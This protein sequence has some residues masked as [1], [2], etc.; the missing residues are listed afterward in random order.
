MIEPGQ[1][2]TDSPLRQVPADYC[3]P[4]AARWHTLAEGPEAGRTLFYYDCVVGDG[5]PEA[6]VLFVHGNPECSYT[7]RHIRDALIA[8]DRPLRLIA[9]DH[10]GFGLSDQARFEMVDFHHARHLAELVRHLDLDDVTLVIHDW[11][12]PIGIGAFL[13]EPARVR[14]L[15]LM[16]TTVF[17]MP[18]EGYTYANWPIPWLPWCRTPSVVPDKLW[19]GVAAYVVSHAEPQSRAA[20][21]W[22]VLRYLGKHARHGFAPGTPEAVWSDQMR[23]VA[24]ARASKRHVRQTPVWGH[25]YRY[26]DPRH[27]PQDNRDFYRRLH[28]MVPEAWGPEGQHIGVAGYFGAWDPCGKPEVIRQ[29]QEA[30]PQMRDRTH[31]YPD[32]GH[33]IEEYKGPE[34]A[35]SILALN[36]LA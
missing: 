16:N 3:P 15:L 22:G 28:R 34:M 6:T 12:G 7:Y 21:L 35:R 20:F 29:W 9:V 11:G 30:L 32:R 27:G 13:D 10:L 19:G 1:I 2:P 33:F 4:G 26:R 25:G 24:N 5:P 31:E 23:S 36:G 8:A 17:P 18:S 14:H